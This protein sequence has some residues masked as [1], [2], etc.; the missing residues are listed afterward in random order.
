[1]R[2]SSYFN[3]R[4]PPLSVDI[5]ASTDAYGAI[6]VRGTRLHDHFC[7]SGRRDPEDIVQKF[8]SVAL[9]DVYLVI[10]HY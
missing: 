8:A 4:F 7:F 3:S 2:S 10:A 6:R 9:P 1:L 5:P